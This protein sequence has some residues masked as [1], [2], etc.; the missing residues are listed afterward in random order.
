MYNFIIQNIAKDKN[1]CIFFHETVAK[2]RGI[3]GTS[4][5]ILFFLKSK[6]SYIACS[7]WIVQ[8][9]AL[10]IGSS[11]IQ[12]IVLYMIKIIKMIAKK[13]QVAIN[14]GTKHNLHNEK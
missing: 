6:R 1:I 2:W 5:W 14:E 8:Y 10:S 9:K 4:G 11:K 7:F 12:T 3:F 13:S